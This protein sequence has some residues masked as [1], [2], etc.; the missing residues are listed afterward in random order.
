ML[1][2]ILIGLV[3]LIVL[4]LIAAGTRPNTV[5]YERSIRIAAPPGRI[6]PHIVDFRKWMPW[7]PWEKKDPDLQRTY[8]GASSGPGAHYHWVG[9]SK[10]GEGHMEVLESGPGG[11]KIDLR[12]IKPWKAVC[13]A[14]FHFTPDDDGTQ[15]RWTMDGPQIF[16]GKVFGLFFN[17]DKA[18]GKD[19]EAGLADLKA[20]AERG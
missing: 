5:H 18:I 3:A 10:V 19:L 1:L 12:F 2:Y 9:N 11:V 16:M 4:V 20:V 17:M 8:S 13:V 14:Q 7:S 15:V 6:L